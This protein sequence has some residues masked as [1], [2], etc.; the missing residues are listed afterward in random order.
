VNHTVGTSSWK[1]SNYKQHSLL[2]TGQFLAAVLIPS[3]CTHHTSGK[4]CT[5]WKR[6]QK[7][8][9]KVFRDLGNMVSMERLEKSGLLTLKDTVI[10]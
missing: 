2:S 8:P 4:M 9:T 1:H 7:R 3:A 6:V 5:N 10:L